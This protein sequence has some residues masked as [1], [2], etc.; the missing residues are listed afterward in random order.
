MVIEALQAAFGFSA[1]VVFGRDDEGPGSGQMYDLGKA[2]D[3]RA[4]PTAA[5]CL[6]LR[7]ASRHPS[8]RPAGL[9]GALVH[10]RGAGREA[11]HEGRQARL[12]PVAQEGLWRAPRAPR[13][14]RCDSP[15]QPPRA[16][17]RARAA[18]PTAPD[19]DRAARPP[20]RA[21]A[22]TNT[23][24]HMRT[25]ARSHARA[26]THARSHLCMGSREKAVTSSLSYFNFY[27]RSASTPT[28]D[29]L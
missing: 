11:L 15:S 29:L 1:V 2:Q 23:H 14:L 3:V 17:S 22:Q 16:A 24:A 18:T 19:A 26:C 25:H 7:P 13:P 20:V 28:F 6:H 27:L 10:P 8:T 12:L 21:I 5:R 4:R 9:L